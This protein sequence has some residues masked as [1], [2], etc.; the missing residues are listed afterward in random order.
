MPQTSAAAANY[1]TLSI[2]PTAPPDFD[3]AARIAGAVRLGEL[4]PETLRWFWPLRIPLGRVTLLAGDPGV[5]K[6]LL[7]LDIA[8]RASRGAP[9]PDEQGAM[10]KEQGVGHSSSGS[11][12]PAPSSVLLLTAEDDLA[13]TVLPRLAALGA[14]LAKVVAIPAVPG[15]HVEPLPSISMPGTVATGESS[16]QADRR[17]IANRAFE[18]RRDLA[19]LD[20]LLRAMPDCR[21]VI[22]DPISAYLGDVNE[23]ANSEVRGLMLPLAALAHQHGVAVLAVTHLRKKEGAAIYRAMGS[24]AFVAAARAAWLVAKDPRS[25]QRRLLLPMKN[26]LAPDVTGLAFTIESQAAT[27]VPAIHWS[28]DPVAS[29]AE[30][31][32][33]NSRPRGRPDHQREDAMDWLKSRLASGPAPAADVLEEADGHGINKET[34]RRAFR[35]LRGEAVKD[36]FGPFGQWLWKLPAASPPTSH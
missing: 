6:S 23:Q 13:E 12:L 8:A 26:N 4:G 36:G 35:A 10:S 28:P 24:L 19:R 20:Q 29:S 25:A 15:Q 11:M 5:G 1:S 22:V 2:G 34:L 32:V 30:S 33:G 14:E 27:T 18:L 21:L 9:W 31:I 16:G 3:R 17:P 7:A